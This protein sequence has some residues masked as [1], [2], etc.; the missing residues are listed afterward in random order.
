MEPRIQALAIDFS[1]AL[2]AIVVGILA[3][4]GRS[5]WS[6]PLIVLGF[7][8]LV[9][10]LYLAEHT[11]LLAFVDDHRPLSLVVAGLATFVVALALVVG[12]LVVPVPSGPLLAGA[13]AGLWLYRTVF[14][15]YHPVPPSRLAQTIRGG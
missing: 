8:A 7:C 6:V 5:L 14:G 1:L 11:D 4:A 15:L 12:R 3:G 2:C 13:G 9:G 10:P